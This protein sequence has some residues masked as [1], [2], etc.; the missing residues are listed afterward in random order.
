MVMTVAGAKLA[1]EGVIAKTEKSI[2]REVSYLKELAD[3][4]ATLSHIEQLQ[5]DGEPL[6][7]G[8]PYGSY[9]EWRD[10]I[11]KEIKTGQNSLDRIEI[12]KAEL[13]AFNYFMEN[14]PEA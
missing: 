7:E 13:M 2:E 10:A 8:N 6:P 5:N 4:K 3:D 12:E 14:A 11:E 9:S 1:L